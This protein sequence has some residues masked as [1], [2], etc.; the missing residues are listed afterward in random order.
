M[1]FIRASTFV[2]TAVGHSDPNTGNDYQGIQYYPTISL[3]AVTG[4]DFSRVSL[5]SRFKY[6]TDNQSGCLYT[7]IVTLHILLDSKIK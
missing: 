7:Y 2:N 6:K 3:P 5:S 1:I 4:F